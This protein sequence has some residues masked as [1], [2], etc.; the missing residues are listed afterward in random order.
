MVVVGGGISTKDKRLP[1][2][3]SSVVKEA[4]RLLSVFRVIKYTL[5]VVVKYNIIKVTIVT[6]CM[7]GKAF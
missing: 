5:Y 7:K 4:K 3:K 1:P 6:L 2:G